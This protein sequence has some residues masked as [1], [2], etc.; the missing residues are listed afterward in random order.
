MCG[1]SDRQYFSWLGV[2]QLPASR[3]WPGLSYDSMELPWLLKAWG[4]F[5]SWLFVLG[6]LLMLSCRLLKFIRNFSGW[7]LHLK[8][9]LEL[10]VDHESLFVSGCTSCDVINLCGTKQK[11]MRHLLDSL[12][13]NV[14]VALRRNGLEQIPLWQLRWVTSN[15]IYPKG[16]STH[17]F[18]QTIRK[19]FSRSAVRTILYDLKG[20]KR[21]NISWLNLRPLRRNLL[22]EGHYHF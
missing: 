2:A 14:W 15:I 3:S 13:K 18:L 11:W 17:I 5:G 19:G 6:F 20:T 8:D 4:N 1:Q 12:G 7:F 22:R 9:A 16:V 10:N 21:S